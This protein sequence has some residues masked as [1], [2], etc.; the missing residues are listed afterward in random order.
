L[1]T[2]AI[3]RANSGA[4]GV[5][6]HRVPPLP[7]AIDALEPWTDARTMTRHHDVHHLGYVD[8]L[9]AAVAKLP[10]HQDASALW[11]LCHLREIPHEKRATV[12]HNA[13]GHVNHS[14][15]WQTMTPDSTTEPVAP[16]TGTRR[17]GVSRLADA[18]CSGVAAFIR[19]EQ[20]H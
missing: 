10:Q 13:G 17:V 6:R 14:V 18:P 20:R 5:V 9:N 15:F 1:N 12:H 8:A 7:Y 16:L 2:L 3:E 11:L 19:T 4:D